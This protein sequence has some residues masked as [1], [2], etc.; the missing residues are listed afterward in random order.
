MN[1]VEHAEY[2]LKL[3]GYN[4]DKAN[5]KKRIDSSQDYADRVAQCV[6]ELLKVFSKQGHS[7][8]SADFTIQLFNRLV[9]HKALTEL[10]DNPDEWVDAVAEGYQEENSTS[11]RYQS[12]R[13][14][15][16]FSYDLKT[17]YDMD[18]AENNIY[19]RD[20]NGKFTGYGRLK[21]KEERKWIELKHVEVV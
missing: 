18:A 17:Y 8:M 6:L 13:D 1:T 14:Y 12:K 3:A 9:K 21:P 11:A 5:K 16:C 2:E 7:G 15:S 10:T 20:E 4:I 19:E